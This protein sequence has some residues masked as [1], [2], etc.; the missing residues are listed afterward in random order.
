MTS[1]SSRS[2]FGQVRGLISVTN[3]RGHEI[4][5]QFASGHSSNTI[6]NVTYET[7]DQYLLFYRFHGCEGGEFRV[8]GGFDDDDKGIVGADF[9]LPLT[10][11]FALATGFTLRDPRRRGL[12][13]LG[14]GDLEP[15]HEPRV[16][17]RLPGAAFGSGAVPT[18]VQRRRQRLADHRQPLIGSADKADLSRAARGDAGRPFS[19]VGY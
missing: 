15:R 1:V 14:R 10:D 8:L 17:L 6:N 13:R 2:D 4:G 12:G 9:N 7:T 11:R 19:V 16:A 3:P 18:D 5:F